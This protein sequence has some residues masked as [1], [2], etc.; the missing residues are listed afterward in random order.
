MPEKQNGGITPSASWQAVTCVIAEKA[1][2]AA[3]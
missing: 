2:K 1:A 3:T